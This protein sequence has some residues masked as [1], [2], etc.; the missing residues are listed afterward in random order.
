MRKLRTARATKLTTKNHNNNN[1][2]IKKSDT[3]KKDI[4]RRHLLLVAVVAVREMTPRGQ[5]EPHDPIVRL[6]QGRVHRKVGRASR[7]RL[8]VHLSWGVT[9]IS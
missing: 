3:R 1:R 2:G 6:Q 9:K 5:V 4:H 7:V 8:D